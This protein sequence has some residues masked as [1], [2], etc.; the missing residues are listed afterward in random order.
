MLKKIDDSESLLDTAALA[1][2]QRFV[3]RECRLLDEQRFEEWLALYLPE[4]TYWAPATR[5]NPDPDSQVSLFWDDKETMQTRV[6]RLLHPEIHSQIP[7]SVTVRLTSNF[8]AAVAPGG[9][10]DAYQVE[11]RFIMVEDRLGSPR[12][13][14]AGTFNY[15]LVQ[16]GAA[17]RIR[18]KRVDLTNCDHAFH[19]L[20][21][22]F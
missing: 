15:L 9:E 18:Q 21:Q 22:P 2:L 7:A 19:T 6:Q 11:C 13:Q 8:R 10:K 5:D 4:A 1:P 17:F 20:T 14:F 12:Q 3:E 16:N